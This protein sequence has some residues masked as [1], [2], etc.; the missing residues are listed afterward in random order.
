MDPKLGILGGMGPL[1][2]VDF[3]AKVISA[4]PASI[5]QDHIPTLVYSAS[6]TPD[7][8][9]GILGIGQSPL[10]ALIEGVKLLERGGAALIAIPCN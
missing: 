1:A 10:A 2:T 7:R 5:D 8:S 6:R 4:T 3:L 9:A